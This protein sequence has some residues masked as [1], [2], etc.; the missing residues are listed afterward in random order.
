MGIPGASWKRLIRFRGEDGAENYGEPQLENAQDLMSK[1]E[2]GLEAEI[3]EGTC[4]FEVKSTGKIVKV[5][6]ILHLLQ[7]KD[8]PTVRCIGLNYKTHSKYNFKLIYNISHHLQLV[9]EAGRKPPPYPSL[10]IK[11]NTSIAGWN[12]TVPIPKIAQ[13]D[14]ADYEGE[15]SIVIGKT[16]KNI[17]KDDAIDYVAG[18]VS[19][20]DISSRKWQRDPAYAGGVPQWCFSKGFDKYAPIGPLM[21][22]PAVVG[23]A[24]NLELRTWVNGEER[25]KTNTSDLLFDVR[26]IVSFLSQGTTLEKGTVIMTGTPSGVGFGQAGGPKWLRDGDVVEVEVEHCGRTRNKIV[27]E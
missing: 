10:F 23:A 27:Y 2:T 18:Y 9:A 1:L 24:D 11:A 17:S 25:Q 21:V 15:L 12:E 19:S 6:E 7:P 26:T 14:Q 16:G 13:D 8:V 22:S 4:P 20:N 5:K 3:L